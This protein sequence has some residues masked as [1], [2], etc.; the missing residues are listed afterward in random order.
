VATGHDPTDEPITVLEAATFSWPIIAVTSLGITVGFRIEQPCCSLHKFVVHHFGFDFELLG[1]PIVLDVD[2]PFYP[3][4]IIALD[5]PRSLLI[6][7]SE[8]EDDVHTVRLT[9]FEYE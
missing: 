9:R 2:Q 4:S 1:D 6:G 3:R 7:W 8:D 5:H